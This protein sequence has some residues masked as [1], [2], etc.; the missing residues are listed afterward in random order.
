MGKPSET[1]RYEIRG[2]DCPSCALEI[3]Q[4]LHKNNGLET[5]VLDFAGGTIRFNPVYEGTVRTVLKGI[6]PQAD[7]RIA[8][9]ADSGMAADNRRSNPIPLRLIV[10][11]VLFAMGLIA[12]S[13]AL[14]TP[15]SEWIFFIGSYALAG[16]PV[17]FG[18]V[19]N[20]F[21]GRII[22]EL[23]LMTVATIGAF[24]IGE[25]PEAAAVMLFYAVGEALQ[26]RAVS[27][28]RDA[29]RGAMAL[30]V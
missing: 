13:A 9:S 11:L 20:I 15:W 30:R 1:A 25:L 24:A 29:I 2:I 26:D 22:D 18:A 16:Q 17:V 21:R 6:E 14:G 3:E 10:S 28:S 7:F 23:F 12:R 4:E 19:R 5:A 27:R 8:V